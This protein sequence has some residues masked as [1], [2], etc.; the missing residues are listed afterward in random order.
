[1]DIRFPDFHFT[2]YGDTK[3]RIGVREANILGSGQRFSVFFENNAERSSYALQYENPNIRDTRKSIKIQAADNSDGHHYHFEYQL[4]FYSL[5]SRNAWYMGYEST[6]EI[7]TQYRLGRRLSELG[8][9]KR[10]AELSK[11]FSAGL[12]NGWSKRYTFGL[13]YEKS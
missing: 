11:G 8:H 6:K 3:R 2:R 10:T 9:E 12:K 4:P 1:M 13:R 5:E 7:V